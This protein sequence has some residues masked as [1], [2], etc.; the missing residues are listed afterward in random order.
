M[1]YAKI[2]T[3]DRTQDVTQTIVN[4]AVNKAKGVIE[5]DKKRGFIVSFCATPEEVAAELNKLPLLQT[6]T[7]T[8]ERDRKLAAIEN[9]TLDN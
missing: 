7:F 6:I 3:A 5:Y 4:I 1:I 9:K 8:D 2:K